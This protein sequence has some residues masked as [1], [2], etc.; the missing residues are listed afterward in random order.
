MSFE[1]AIRKAVRW[2]GA[3]GRS[4]QPVFVN[5]ISPE[6]SPAGPCG[7]GAKR[8][9]IGAPIRETLKFGLGWRAG[10][11]SMKRLPLGWD[12][13]SCSVPRW[14]RNNLLRR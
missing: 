10:S 9:A 4:P 6:R 13:I 11:S 1:G 5:T 8:H 7:I 3:N 2:T 12:K 14:P